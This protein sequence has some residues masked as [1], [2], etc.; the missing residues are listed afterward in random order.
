[1]KTVKIIMWLWQAP[2][3]T[4]GFLLSR[5]SCGTNTFYRSGRKAVTVY[6]MPFFFHAGVSLGNYI[7]L[8][9]CY[10]AGGADLSRTVWH[11]AGHSGQSEI[12]G[13]FYL[14]LIGVPSLAGNIYSRAAK[15]DSKWYYGQVWEAW[16]DRLGGVDR[17]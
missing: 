9:D 4:A 11:E 7:L 12:L 14:L 15:K 3:N 6:F 8:D 16:A 2:Q 5:F 10:S 1:M 17:T 13:W